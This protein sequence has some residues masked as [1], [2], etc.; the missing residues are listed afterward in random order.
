[1]VFDSLRYLELGNWQLPEGCVFEDFFSNHSS[2][3][4]EVRILACTVYADPRDIGNW[5]GQNMLLTGVELDLWPGHY[6]WDGSDSGESSSTFHHVEETSTDDELS[7]YSDEESLER[8]RGHYEED[9]WTVQRWQ[10]WENGDLE[11]LWLCG[12]P[13]HLLAATKS[14]FFLSFQK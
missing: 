9:G 13:Y 1:M 10:C 3:L 4:K 14:I 5:V 6:D 8:V 12:R 2:T 7:G 11:A